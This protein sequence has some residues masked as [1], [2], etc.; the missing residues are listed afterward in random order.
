MSFDK[1]DE[2]RREEIREA[3]NFILVR[4]ESCLFMIG[5]LLARGLHQE[6]LR[7]FEA[8]EPLLPPEVRREAEKHLAI[9]KAAKKVIKAAVAKPTTP[10]DKMRMRRLTAAGYHDLMLETLE[11]IQDAMF[12]YQLRTRGFTG[13]DLSQ[14][15]MEKADFE[16]EPEP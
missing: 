16:V 12:K 14:T 13:V 1:E 4:I 9:L 3:K 7:R 10:Y 15:R 8:L 11:L 2:L 5:D 6:A